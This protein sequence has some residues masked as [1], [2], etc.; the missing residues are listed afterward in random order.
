MVIKSKLNPKAPEFVPHQVANQTLKHDW[1]A[2]DPPDQDW[3]PD[4]TEEW[5]EQTE[6]EQEALDPLLQTEQAVQSLISMPGGFHEVMTPLVTLLKATV[7]DREILEHVLS[8]IFENSVNESNFHYSG[9]RMCSYLCNN[10]E[11]PSHLGTFR[12]SLMKRCQQE[13]NQRETL[14]ADVNTEA[15]VIGFTLFMAELFLQLKVNDS[16]VRV[17][18]MGVRQLLI[19]VLSKPSDTNIKSALQVLKLTGR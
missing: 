19:T 12:Q 10:L 16:P 6:L 13:H 7:S 11:L 17:L 18:A 8:I 14:I 9:A 2:G 15:R 5:I 1:S 3:S 4:A